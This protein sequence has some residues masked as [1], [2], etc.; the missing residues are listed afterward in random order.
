MKSPGDYHI[1]IGMMQGNKGKVRCIVS[2]KDIFSTKSF[3][4][5]FG[6]SNTYTSLFLYVKEFNIINPQHIFQEFYNI[7]QLKS[8]REF[9]L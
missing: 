3:C 1:I 9:P 7:L 4:C 8:P 6:T 5:L 2:G